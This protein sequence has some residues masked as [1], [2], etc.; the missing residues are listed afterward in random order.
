MLP[1]IVDRYRRDAAM[2]AGQPDGAL[3]AVRDDEDVLD[4][5]APG[6]TAWER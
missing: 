2:L 6:H 4:R 5:L 3:I 1:P